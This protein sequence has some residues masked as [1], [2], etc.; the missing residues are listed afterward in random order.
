MKI[1]VT[2]GA[3]FIG[4]HLV[5]RLIDT[6]H[7]VRIFDNLEPQVHGSILPA[8]INP[9]AEFV[10]G[11][12]RNKDQLRDALTGMDCIYHLAAATGVGQSMYQIEKYFGVNVQGTANL[13]DI[14][15]N[16]K[17][18]VKKIILSS[19]RAVYGEGEYR[20]DQCGIVFPKLR[21][22]E[23]LRMGQ[24]EVR[25]PNCN[26]CLEANLTPESKPANPGSIYGVT[27][28]TQEMMVSTFSQAY[29]IQ[30]TI[31]RF[32]NVYGPRQSQ[33]NPYTGIFSAFYNCLSAGKAPEVYEDGKM[34]RDFVEV[35]D[36]VTACVLALKTEERGQT[37]YNIG[38]GN[39]I[40]ILEAANIFCD[41]IEPRIRPQIVGKARLGDIAACTADISAARTR[42]GYF[43]SISLN[44]GL[45]RL[46]EY[47][48]ENWSPPDTLAAQAESELREAGLLLSGN[49]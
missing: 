26:G 40:S 16:E 32:F 19:S 42:L 2:G 33:H 9:K 11:D 39:A 38:T 41:L 44:Y 8:Y 28:L 31:L 5:D 22:P 14:L 34:T 37:T 7:Q 46:I 23:Q 49:D 25:C 17:H 1:F 43:P 12:V 18:G 47:M 13:L 36:V 4:S 30:A 15:A 27:K 35:S 29:G 10:R 6:G 21:L 20:C 24:W 45:P 48:K 3:G